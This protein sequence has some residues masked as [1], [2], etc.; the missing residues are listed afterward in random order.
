[1]RFSRALRN[2]VHNVA[3]SASI[4]YGN[5]SICDDFGDDGAKVGARVGAR[6]EGLFV[7]LPVAIS[8]GTGVGVGVG[9]N[10]GLCV[11]S[12]IGLAVGEEDTSTVSPGDG[13]EGAS[14]DG[15]AS[16]LSPFGVCGVE[17]A[18]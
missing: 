5:F 16:S 9:G 12:M 13:D 15:T 2:S 7:G 17:E 10:D 1:V 14:V 8:V 4:S 3:V 18:S 6:D 11:S